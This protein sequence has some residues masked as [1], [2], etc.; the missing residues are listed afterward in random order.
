MAS[1]IWVGTHD[2]IKKG[3]L[4]NKTALAV[5]LKLVEAA[6][7]SWRRLDGPNQLP[8]VVPGAKFSD[9]LEVAPPCRSS[10]RS[11]RLI[12]QAVIKNWR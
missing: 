11:R 6:Q 10:V 5:V 9:G 8:K 1:A 4:S 3:C 12:H 2:P 7:R